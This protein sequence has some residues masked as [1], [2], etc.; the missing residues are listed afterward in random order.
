M[1]LIRDLLYGLIL[2]VMT[3]FL[4]WRRFFQRRYKG[5]WSERFGS[6]PICEPGKKRIWIHGVSLGEINASRTLVDKFQ[7]ELPDC[8]IVIT[9]TTDTG[10]ARAKNLY[11]QKHTICFYPWDF[12]FAVR[13]ALKRLKPSVCVMMEGEVWPNFTA[14][15]KKLNIPVVVANGRVGGSKGWPRYKK[16]APLV[17]GMFSRL[18]LVLAQDQTAAERFTFLGVAPENVQVVGSIKYDT[19]EITDQVNGADKLASQLQLQ[20]DEPL[21]VAGSTG[22]DEE[23][24]I[25]AAYEKVQK[26]FEKNLR[27]AIIP[28]KPERFD[29]VAGLIGGSGHKLIRYSEIKKGA[30]LGTEA[31]KAVI[32]GDTMGDLR[33][34]Y[35]L[36]N[37]IF[38]GRSLVPM[39][40]SDMIEAAAL[41]KPVIV[42]PFTDNFLESVRLLVAGNAI[43]VVADQQQLAQMVCDFL[44]DSQ[45][46]N[47]LATNA[48]NVIKDNQGATQKSV[49]AIC[50]ILNT[51]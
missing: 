31:N 21:W 9:T 46:A 28:R 26:R 42:G 48:R 12:S 23:A 49:Q 13:K 18:R 47:N 1:T 11:S 50:E 41:G 22:I 6:A 19:A 29:E 37:V 45:K 25:L 27:L 5:G 7:S 30:Q 51:L 39:G 16:I 38:V 40:G 10:M 33:K 3:P 2:I 43:E 20:P 15:A 4:L 14:I 8:E 36:A 24:I 17:R 35:S 34:F 32:L 44:T